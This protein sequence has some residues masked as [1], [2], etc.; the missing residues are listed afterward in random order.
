MSKDDSG[1]KTAKT[2]G[3]LDETIA[4]LYE[5][6]K[7][8]LGQILCD[9]GPYAPYGRA[10]PSSIMKAQSNE[11][12]GSYKLKDMQLEYETIESESLAQKVRS[13]YEVGRS[14]AHDY[15]TLLKTLSLS[16][17]STR[18]VIDINIPRSLKAINLLFTKPGAKNSENY[19]FPNITKVSVTVEGNAND[20]YSDG[21]MQRK[22]YDE[23]RRYFE[24]KVVKDNVSCREYYTNKFAMVIDFRTVDDD[25]VVGSGRSLMGTQSGILLEIEKDGMA[26]T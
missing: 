4:T 25:T 9:H 18:K 24:C 12:V 16:K 11:S 6:K 17:R 10:A 26:E 15:S 13:S 2:N 21:L 14:L 5:R 3:V 7:I 19:P 1:N 23:A 8:S 20:I 22:M